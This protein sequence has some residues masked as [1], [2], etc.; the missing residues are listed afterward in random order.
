[1]STRRGRDGWGWMRLLG[2]SGV[3]GILTMQVCA[4][5]GRDGVLLHKGLAL[6][7]S[8]LPRLKQTQTP[9]TT[10]TTSYS[11]FP[12]PARLACPPPSL[13]PAAPTRGQ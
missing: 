4:F 13:A 9:S 2:L 12:T 3:A 6:P 5:Y 7:A 1:M 11:C 8:F 10:T